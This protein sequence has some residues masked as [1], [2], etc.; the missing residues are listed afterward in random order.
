MFYLQ[1]KYFL[2]QLLNLW[3][4]VSE[5]HPQFLWL[6][7]KDHQNGLKR[8]WE[9]K[10]EGEGEDEGEGEGRKRDKRGREGREMRNKDIHKSET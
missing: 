4:D 5:L 10:E 1:S 7:N 8:Q 9:R 2:I 6:V 3:C